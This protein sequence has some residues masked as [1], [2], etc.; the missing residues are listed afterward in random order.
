M[1]KV[2]NVKDLSLIF[3]AAA[4]VVFVASLFAIDF[5]GA[6]GVA[7]CSG[8]SLVMLFFSINLYIR[9]KE[10]DNVGN[11]LLSLLTIAL[12]FLGAVTVFVTAPQLMH[13]FH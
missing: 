10:W 13:Y 3:M 2:V 11:I 4:I 6:T 9:K 12:L 7:I 5:L 1:K 8:V